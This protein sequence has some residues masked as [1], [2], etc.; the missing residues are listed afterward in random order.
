[1]KTLLLTGWTGYIWS[2]NAVLFLEKWYEVI[3][4]DNLSNSSDSVVTTIETITGKKPQF[5]KWDLRNKQDIE[6][7]FEKHT[8]DTVIHFAWAKAVGQSCDDPFYYYENNILWSLHLFQ[9]MEEYNCKNIIFSS[10]A[11][12]YGP[13]GI[14]PFTENH[15]VGDT[16]NPYG[17]TKYMIERLL[18]DLHMQA[19]FNVVNLRYFNPVGAHKSW[20]IGEHAN[21]QLW[22]I[23]PFLLRVAN[24]EQEKI[25]VY[26]N[27]YDTYDGTG[28]RDYIH[29]VD[30]AEWHLAALEYMD[31]K[32]L[33]ESINL[34]TGMGT[35][36]MELIEIVKTQTQ[37]DIPFE[38]VWRRDI[39]IATAYCSPE[40]AK[41]LLWWEAQ[42]TVQQAVADSW[43]FIQQQWK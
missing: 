34:G 21:Q 37:R 11:N 3:L 36:V 6:Q 23:L 27:D 5:Y 35:S 4:F 18:R 41:E 31:S 12:V 16:S 19:Q 25:Q 33:H 7:I 15:T 14:S 26:G 8:I 40:K 10:S 24:G 30:L 9:T 28:I 39:D 29:V 13:D 42:K 17:T 43:N 1:M 32:H 22:N 38:I 2:H 20:L